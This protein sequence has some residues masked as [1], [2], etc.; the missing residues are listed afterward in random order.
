[1]FRVSSHED[2]LGIGC[3]L[4]FCSTSCM[5]GMAKNKM[6]QLFL[7]FFVHI[8]YIYCIPTYDVLFFS[9]P[10]LCCVLGPIP[11]TEECAPKKNGTPLEN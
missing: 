6:K 5:H 3:E 10:F 1:M 11:T 7:Y 8:Y 4:D 2:S 9:S